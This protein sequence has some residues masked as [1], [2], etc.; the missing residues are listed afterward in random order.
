[1]TFS[2]AQSILETPVRSALFSSGNIL[3]KRLATPGENADASA[4][5]HVGHRLRNSRESRLKFIGGHCDQSSKSAHR[6]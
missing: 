1:M 2:L 5:I 6:G 4:A 3:P